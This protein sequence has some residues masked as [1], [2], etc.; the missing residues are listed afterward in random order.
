MRRWILVLPQL[1]TLLTV[2]M[3][4]AA[5]QRYGLGLSL[6]RLLQAL[7]QSEAFLP[8]HPLAVLAFRVIGSLYVLG[9]RVLLKDDSPS[10]GTPE[11]K[12]SEHVLLA[13]AVFA[14]AFL[15]LG[16]KP[17]S[18]LLL[19]PVLA[20]VA[21][22]GMEAG[23]PLPD[24]SAPASGRLECCRTPHAIVRCSAFCRTFTVRTIN[25]T[26]DQ[27]SA[28]LVAREVNDAEHCRYG[29]RD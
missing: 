17:R 19:V 6:L 18:G 1:R 3:E 24:R 10:G 7:S 23:P 22:L 29:T 15:G 26:E 5:A 27:H 12:N 28:T 2:H 13:L 14:I 9:I 4:Y 25:P 20:P 21:A 11:L 8:W 16:G